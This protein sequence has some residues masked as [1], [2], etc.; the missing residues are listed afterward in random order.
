MHIYFCLFPQKHELICSFPEYIVTGQYILFPWFPYN[1]LT[2]YT[3]LDN[4]AQLTTQES[5]PYRC[6]TWE[7][8]KKTYKLLNKRALKISAWYKNCIFKC[9]GKIVCVEY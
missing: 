1:N 6:G 9:M 3:Q 2:R 8:S 5:V 7:G 4:P